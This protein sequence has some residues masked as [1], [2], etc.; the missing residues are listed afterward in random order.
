METK[1]F[2]THNTVGKLFVFRPL[3]S[4]VQVAEASVSN[5]LKQSFGGSARGLFI[6]LLESGSLKASELRELEG[7]IRKHRKAEEA[8]A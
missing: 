2:I 6:N 7:L 4:E 3:V 1:G 8:D 5:L